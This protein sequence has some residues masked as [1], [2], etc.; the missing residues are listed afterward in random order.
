MGRRK[1]RREGGKRKTRK[2]KSG[3]GKYVTNPPLQILDPPLFS[4]L[5]LQL[6]SGPKPDCF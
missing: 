2:G 1:G 4:V 6:Q 5:T 3:E